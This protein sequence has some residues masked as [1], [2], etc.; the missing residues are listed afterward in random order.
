MKKIEIIVIAIIS[1]FLLTGCV[2]KTTDAYKFK[3]EYESINNKDTGNGNKYR[4]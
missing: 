2:D 4:K 3:E 1:L